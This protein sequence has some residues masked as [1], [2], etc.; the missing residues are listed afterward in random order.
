MDSNNPYAF[1]ALDWHWTL[2]L[3]IFNV[4]LPSLVYYAFAYNSTTASTTRKTALE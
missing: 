4:G 1:V 3:A 2:W